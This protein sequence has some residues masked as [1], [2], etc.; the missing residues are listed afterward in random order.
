MYERGYKQN[1]HLPRKIMVD[2]DEQNY[3]IGDFRTNSDIMGMRSQLI[4]TAQFLAEFFS[5]TRDSVEK[6]WERNI[7]K[8]VSF[9]E[10]QIIFL[11]KALEDNQRRR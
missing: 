9:W 2:F 10:E 4:E 6:V 1:I 11:Y 8:S 3:R 5:I 7:S